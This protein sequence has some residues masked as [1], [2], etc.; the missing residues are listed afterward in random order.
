M[1]IKEASK[2]NFWSVFSVL[3]VLVLISFVSAG[4]F[5]WITGQASS[6]ETNVSVTIQGTNPTVIQVFNESLG[7]VSPTEANT[8]LVSF[9]V[10]V[11]DADGVNDIVDSSVTVNFSRAGEELRLNATCQFVADVDSTTANYTCAADMFWYDEAGAWTISVGANDT[12]NGTFQ[13]N[14]TQSFTYSELKALVISPAALTWAT[15][16]TGAVNQSSSNDPTVIN[17]TGNFNGTINLTGINILG[18]TNNSDFIDVANFTTA[19]FTGS[20]AE[21]AVANGDNVTVLTNATAVVV[22]SSVANRGNF[23][24]GTG[25]GQEDFYYCIPVVPTVPSQTY[26]TTAGGAWTILY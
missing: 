6:Q 18:E 15:L 16:S 13:Y 3:T 4:P 5:D 8:T 24:A 23:T 10:L 25:A 21:C 12:G 14:T 1:V 19:L 17:N 11:S 22:N 20:N 7:A 9:E 26:S 2:K